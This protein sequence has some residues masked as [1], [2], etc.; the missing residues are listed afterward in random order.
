MALVAAY[1]TLLAIGGERQSEDICTRNGAIDSSE[2]KIALDGIE[3]W[4]PFL[5]GGQWL[6]LT[7][8]PEPR[9]RLAAVAF[10]EVIYTFGGQQSYDPSCDCHKTTDE[11]AMY[12]VGFDDEE[13]AGPTV[14]QTQSPI[15]TP[16][17]LAP[18]VDISNATGWPSS[19]ATG[20]PSSNVS[21]SILVTDAPTTPAVDVDDTAAPSDLSTS[22]AITGN[23]AL[24]SRT[25]NEATTSSAA[26]KWNLAAIIL[27]VFQV[28][29]CF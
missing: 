12:K 16:A 8:L 19:N 9:A 22:A 20:W 2:L 13:E 26:T 10:D 25:T 11:V 23:V 3:I 5:A 27:F 24:A 14:V 4:D 29:A 28:F 6:T 1:G 21:T 15:Q 17:T 18:T 7:F